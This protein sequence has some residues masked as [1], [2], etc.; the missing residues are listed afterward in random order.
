[1]YTL[2]RSIMYATSYL[3][4]CVLFTPILVQT[5]GFGCECGDNKCGG[6][7]VGISAGTN[8][9]ASV[10]ATATG[11]GAAAGNCAAG[12]GHKQP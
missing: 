1:M 9:G 5:S 10:A 3:V 2:L 8:A 7:Y 12:D 6:K 4:S 11:I